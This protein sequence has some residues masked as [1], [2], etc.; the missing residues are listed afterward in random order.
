MNLS[1]YVKNKPVDVYKGGH[2]FN[3]RGYSL[4]PSGYSVA[5]KVSSEELENAKNAA[6]ESARKQQFEINKIYIQDS[7]ANAQKANAEAYKEQQRA[8]AR[9]EAAALR[10]AQAQAQETE[11]QA[12]AEVLPAAVETQ[13][14]EASPVVVNYYTQPRTRVNMK[15]LLLVGG[16]VFA[17][18]MIF[19]RR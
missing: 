4:D 15:T 19:G 7:V 3:P 14:A 18:W 8:K 13:A 9:E 11:N 10:L 6:I 2:I 1:Q 16:V 5:E 12:A 17:Y